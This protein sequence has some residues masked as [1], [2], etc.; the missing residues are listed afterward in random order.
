MARHEIWVVHPWPIGYIVWMLSTLL[1]KPATPL[2]VEH[3]FQLLNCRISVHCWW[4]ARQ[5]LT[6]M[7]NCQMYLDWVANLSTACERLTTSTCRGLPVEIQ[8]N[9]T[10]QVVLYQPT[11]ITEV[12]VIVAC[13][14]YS[15]LKVNIS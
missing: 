12:I 5:R 13:L 7:S 1:L 15:E 6:N 3:S 10:Q 2:I 9:K 14:N 11:W 8:V 4:A